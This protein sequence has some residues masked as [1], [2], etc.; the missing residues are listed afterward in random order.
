MRVRACEQCYQPACSER[1]RAARAAFI[2]QTKWRSQAVD[3]VESPRKGKNAMTSIELGELLKLSIAPTELIVRGT[4]MYWFLFLI[5]RFVLRRDMGSAG[6]SDILFLVLL[7]DAAQNGMI[8]EGMTV[9]DSA[10]L[11]AT[12][13]AWN[14]LLNY[15]GYHIRAIEWLTDPPPICLIRNGR[16]LRANLRREHL[17]DLEIESKL[18]AEGIEKIGDVKCMYLESDGSF[19]VLRRPK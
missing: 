17:T 18:R 1:E 8:G 6:L 19:S 7:G 15:A 14:Y 12:L 2:A 5:F 13:V 10:L 4:L 16:K 11:V 9:A 3:P